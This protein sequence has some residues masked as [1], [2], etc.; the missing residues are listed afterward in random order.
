MFKA[1]G[2]EGMKKLILLVCILFLS[3]SMIQAQDLA[4][5]IS[6]ITALASS[7]VPEQKT[8]AL[9]GIEKLLNEDPAGEDVRTLLNILAGLA[10]EG[11]TNLKVD[12]GTVLNDFPAIRLEAVR[13]L[14]NTGSPEAMSI[15][16]SVLRNEHDLII[17]SEASL[18]ASRLETASWKTLTPYF[19]RIL[20]LQKDVYRNDQ[21]IQDVLISI[22]NIADRDE[23]ILSDPKILEGIVFIAEEELGFSKK[24]VA[25]ADEMKKRKLKE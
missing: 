15:L 2:S 5:R 21:L 23:S 16:V 24:T 17:I 10:S 20:K 11:T 13:L 8:E 19:Q 12:Q 22:R 1:G 14:G 6:I 4:G 7:S 18:A 3:F 9:R 25:L